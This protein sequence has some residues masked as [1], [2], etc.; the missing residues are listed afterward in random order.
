MV[1]HGCVPRGPNAALH[2]L[3][4]IWLTLS[5]PIK[6]ITDAIVSVSN[7]DH[8]GCIKFLIIALLFFLGYQGGR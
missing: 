5:K 6:S 2:G 7:I 8:E 4:H 3:F 1:L